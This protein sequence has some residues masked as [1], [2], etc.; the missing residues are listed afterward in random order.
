MPASLLMAASVCFRACTCRITRCTHLLTRYDNHKVA[1]ILLGS[2]ERHRLATSDYLASLLEGTTEINRVGKGLLPDDMTEIAAYV[3]AH[4]KVERLFLSGNNLGLAGA[5][6]LSALLHDSKLRL[7]RLDL[8]HNN[9]GDDGCSALAAA[10]A[11]NATLSRIDLS[12]NG[13]TS[14]AAGALAVISLSLSLS[15][16]L[17]HQSHIHH[18]PCMHACMHPS[19]HPS[20]HPCTVQ[21]MLGKNERLSRLDLRHNDL[22]DGG[23]ATLAA[24]I[25][26]KCVLQHLDLS[27][28]SIGHKGAE[29]LAGALKVN[30]LLQV[31][32][33]RGNAVSPVGVQA[34]EDSR[35]GSAVADRQVLLPLATR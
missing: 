10:V 1:K 6:L 23:A 21:V 4:P 15:L 7:Q 3:S 17:T 19:I 33:M 34:L 12:A 27:A 11:D 18:P 35:S 22:G 29:A 24:A 9:L 30:T 26:G 25:K 16:C 20:I 5:R 31:L 13:I 8:R 2:S 32:D 14:A 28:N